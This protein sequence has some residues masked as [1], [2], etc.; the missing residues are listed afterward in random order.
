MRLFLGSLKCGH[1]IAHQITDGMKIN[2]GGLPILMPQIFLI[3][4]FDL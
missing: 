4:D 2:L 3:F 1:G